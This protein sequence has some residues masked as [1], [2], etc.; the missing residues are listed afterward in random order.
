[1]P[2]RFCQ[3]RRMPVWMIGVAGFIILQ[4]TVLTVEAPRIERS[5]S[6]ATQQVLGKHGLS[7]ISATVSGRDVT[8]SGQA[9]SVTFEAFAQTLVFGVT[10][11]RSADSALQ[12]QPL[13]LPHLLV[14]RDR[15]GELFISGELSSAHLAEQVLRIVSKNIE[16]KHVNN[17]LQINREV[18][19]A[20][21]IQFVEQVAVEANLLGACEFEIGGG[22]VEMSGFLSNLSEYT[23][24]I[25]R[26]LEFL[27]DSSLNL[28]NRVAI[29]PTG[30]AT[31]QSSVENEDVKLVYTD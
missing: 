1:M 9:P 23:M 19:E 22:R 2:L 25:N 16:H 7:R 11:V 28:I 6:S 8:L 31:S 26:M 4:I 3:L 13:R 17:M 27:S 12:I 5:L 24:F 20:R 10:G 15:A 29:V 30:F 14:S 21:W 18:S